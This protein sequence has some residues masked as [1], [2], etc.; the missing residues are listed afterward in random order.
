MK[1]RQFFV[2][3]FTLAMVAASVASVQNWWGGKPI[4]QTSDE[5]WTLINPA[6]YAFSI[7]ALIYAG[8]LLFGIYQALPAQRE[9]P[10]FKDASGWIMINAIA[11]I[12]WYPAAHY[13]LMNMGLSQIFLGLMVFSLLHINR[14]LQIRETAVST[15]ES[16]L[17]RIPFAIYF[18]WV[19]VAMPVSL[20]GYLTFNA[21]KG[22]GITA[23]MWAVI[24]LAV[25]LMIALFTYFRVT[26][27]FYLLTIAWGFAAIAVAQQ[28]T[29]KVVYLTAI[30]GAAITLVVGIVSALSQRRVESMVVE[31]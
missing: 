7:W 31:H 9:N 24:I 14:A 1:A 23:D 29:S 27:F 22:A 10:R 26:H 19:T 4:N 28:S 12:L 17:A 20:A 16:L 8:L 25:S 15:G 13:Q 30:T 2:F 18:G 11:N 3:L 6:P 5:S 21:W